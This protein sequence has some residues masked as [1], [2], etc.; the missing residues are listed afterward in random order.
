MRQD[1][2]TV[3]VRTPVRLDAALKAPI[4]CTSAVAYNYN[5]NIIIIN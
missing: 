1:T 2:G 5:N 3:S 4:N